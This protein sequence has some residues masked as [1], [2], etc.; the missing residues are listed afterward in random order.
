MKVGRAE[1]IKALISPSKFRPAEFTLN[2]VM[3]K[4][5]K[6]LISKLM[7]Y[8]PSTKERKTAK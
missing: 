8:P 6:R 4:S 5:Y 3:L 1:E 7:L 2:E